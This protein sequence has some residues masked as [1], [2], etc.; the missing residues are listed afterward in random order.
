M[1]WHQ[2][3]A[4]KGKD[5]DLFYTAAYEPLALGICGRCPVRFECLEDDLATAHAA[6]DVLGVRGGLPE[7]DRRRLWRERRGPGAWAGWSV[8]DRRTG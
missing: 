8:W 7:H 1:T 2:H 4:C 5:T 6:A 3:A